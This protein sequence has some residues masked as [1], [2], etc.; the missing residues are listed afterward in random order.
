MAMDH[1]TNDLPRSPVTTD[2]MAGNGATVI[3]EKG[4]FGSNFSH[5]G[6]FCL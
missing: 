6:S 1:R 2:E 3:D 4:F 5:E